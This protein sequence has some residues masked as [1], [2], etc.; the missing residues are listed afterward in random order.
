MKSLIEKIQKLG[1]EDSF[2]AI[3]DDLLKANSEKR[4]ACYALL[5]AKLDDKDANIRHAAVKTLSWE[6]L[7]QKSYFNPIQKKQVFDNLVYKMDH[8]KTT[9]IKKSAVKSVVMAIKKASVS[10]VKPDDREFYLDKVAGKLS[11]RN[12]ELAVRQTAETALIQNIINSD[13][14]LNK[15]QNDKYIVQIATHPP[16]YSNLDSTA[17]MNWANN[18]IKMLTPVK[19]D[20]RNAILFTETLLSLEDKRLSRIIGVIEYDPQKGFVKKPHKN[21]L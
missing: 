13:D 9:R 18:T 3:R 11:M 12:R 19:S 4:D 17:I 5:L 2:R 14:F 6:I 10:G 7:Q 21:T 16:L 8:E 15:N 1:T 20:K